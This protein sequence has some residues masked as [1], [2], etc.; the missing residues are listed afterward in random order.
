MLN[1][2]LALIGDKP[3]LIDEWQEVPSMW[4]AVRGKVDGAIEKGQFILTELAT[5]NK[6]NYIHSGTGRIARLKMRPMSLYESG[7]SDGRLHI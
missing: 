5:I 1:P 4:D 3:R 2:E 6:N 7:Y